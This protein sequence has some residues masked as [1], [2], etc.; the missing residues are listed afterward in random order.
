MTKSMA[1]APECL[2]IIIIV[3][4][5]KSCLNNGGATSVEQANK[6]TQTSLDIR[7]PT[8]YSKI[9]HLSPSTIISKKWWAVGK[10]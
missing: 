9:C 3:Y 7:P 2:D 1:K 10:P 8:L 5:K 6:T 4:T